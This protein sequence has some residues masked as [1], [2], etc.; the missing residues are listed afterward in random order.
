MD[1][2]W[3]LHAPSTDTTQHPKAL[4][5]AVATSTVQ[6]CGMR[7]MLHAATLRFAP[8]NPTAILGHPKFRTATP[9]VRVPCTV[10]RPASGYPTG[11]SGSKRVLPVVFWHGTEANFK[12]PH[13][14]CMRYARMVSSPA[15]VSLKLAYTGERVTDSMR[16]SSMEE[17]LGAGGGGWARV[18]GCIRVGGCVYI[19]MVWGVRAVGTGEPMRTECADAQRRTLSGGGGGTAGPGQGEL[20]NVV[21]GGRACRM[22]WGSRACQEAQS[23]CT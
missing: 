2:G 12:C 13:L 23:R 19:Y 5:P 20:C 7:H 21:Q 16:C 9:P 18:F 4:S 14:S 1:C 11:K 8:P 6:A 10:S 17:R 15:M 22:G 3:R